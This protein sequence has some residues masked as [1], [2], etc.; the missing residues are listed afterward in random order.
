MKVRL[1]ENKEQT[2]KGKTKIISHKGEI[3]NV[4]SEQKDIYIVKNPHDSYGF[5]VLK[6]KVEVVKKK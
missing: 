6:S 3:F 1:L 2:K 4:I 5:S